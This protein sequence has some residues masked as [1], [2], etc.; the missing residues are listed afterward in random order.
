MPAIL[1][2]GFVGMSDEIPVY[3]QLGS[4]HEI[5]LARTN[6]HVRI[7]LDRYRLEDDVI[8]WL[9]ENAANAYRLKQ[10][11]GRW[12]IKHPWAL[13]IRFSDLNTA[14]LFRMRFS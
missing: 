13:G 12:A 7:V 10:C 11:E 6:P 3:E 5:R 4:W 2:N 14:L 9:N 8:V 1:P